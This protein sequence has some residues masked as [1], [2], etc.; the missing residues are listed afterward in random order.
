MVNLMQWPTNQITR[1]FKKQSL[2]G[3]LTQVYDVLSVKIK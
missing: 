3:Q 1:T 2:I